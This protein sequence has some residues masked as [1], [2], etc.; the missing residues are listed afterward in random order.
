MTAEQEL[1]KRFDALGNK[2]KELLL[3]IAECLAADS[4]KQQKSS[5]RLTLIVGGK[6]NRQNA[7]NKI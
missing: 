5:A 2:D 3:A 4:Y 6:E 7:K 1:I